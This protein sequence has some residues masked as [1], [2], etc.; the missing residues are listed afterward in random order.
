MPTICTKGSKEK[1]A[2]LKEYNFGGVMKNPFGIKTR[3]CS[4]KDYAFVY[5]LTNKLLFPY[6]PKYAKISKKE[7]DEDFYKRHKEILILIKGK[8][9]IGFYHISPDIY[10]K[11]ALYLSKIIISPTYQEKKI[12][13]FLMKHFE[14]LGYDK[15]K[16]QV[17]RNNPAFHFYVKLGYRIIS[18]KGGKYLMEKNIGNN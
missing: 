10:E 3:K 16:L 6:I 5:G 1:P 17:W 2:K 15:I 8:R 4:K 14:T 13:S 12:G 11:R 7:F 18:R 9:R